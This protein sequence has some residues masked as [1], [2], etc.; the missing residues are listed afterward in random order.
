MCKRQTRQLTSQISPRSLDEL[1]DIIHPTDFATLANSNVSFDFR[2]VVGN[3][4]DNVAKQR[5]KGNQVHAQMSDHVI[6]SI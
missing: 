1:A 3:T 5:E 6:I 2:L 4:A